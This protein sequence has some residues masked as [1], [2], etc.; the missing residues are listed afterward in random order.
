[1][2][3]PRFTAEASVQIDQSRRACQFNARA[4]SQLLRSSDWRVEPAR[5]IEEMTKGSNG[6]GGVPI[7]TGDNPCDDALTACYGSCALSAASGPGLAACIWG[8]SL[9]YFWCKLF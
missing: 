5:F 7:G 8:C 6:T 9:A 1:M 3:A 4:D 2:I